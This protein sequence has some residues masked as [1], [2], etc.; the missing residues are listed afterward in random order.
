[1]NVTLFG[2]QSD[3]IFNF[4]SFFKPKKAQPFFSPIIQID[5]GGKLLFFV[6]KM[7]AFFCAP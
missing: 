1:M 4:F 2:F 3:L 7:L 5:L 6:Y